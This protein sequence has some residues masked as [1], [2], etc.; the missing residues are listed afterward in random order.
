MHLSLG[1]GLGVQRRNSRSYVGSARFNG[2]TSIV[3]KVTPVGINTGTA[4]RSVHGWI[5]LL[6]NA[7]GT[8]FQF[9]VGGGP[10]CN[11]FL[12]GQSGGTF[13]FFSDRVNVG[14]NM[15][16]TT[17]QFDDNIGLNR[18]AFLSWSLTTSTCSLFANGFLVKT[19]ALGNAINTVAFE[20]L[21]IGMGKSSAGVNIQCVNGDIADG[22]VSNGATSL[23]EHQA[24]F[25]FAVMPPAPVSRFLLATDG[26]DSIGAN[27]ATTTAV[28]FS[29]SH[30]PV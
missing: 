1:L 12:L 14:N 4:S 13:F 21:L 5:Y 8:P 27:S 30:F 19:Q 9:H 16:I 7:L 17:A 23:E 26:T 20:S 2:S 18:W 22:V 3:E 24:L 15:T 29:S 28:T 6:T 25:N 11:A 10:Q